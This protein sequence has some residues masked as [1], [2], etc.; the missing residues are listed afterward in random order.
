MS[1]LSKLS[2]KAPKNELKD[3]T[4]C[5]PNSFFYFSFL[6]CGRRFNYFNYAQ[7]RII[8]VRYILGPFR[9]MLGH[10]GLRNQPLIVLL[11]N[12]GHYIRSVSKKLT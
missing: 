4:Y 9:V 12:P 3:V 8:N 10:W 6:G 2:S 1:F 11:G 5:P 7:I